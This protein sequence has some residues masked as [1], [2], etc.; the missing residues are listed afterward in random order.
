MG[1][2]LIFI[3]LSPNVEK[4]D[5]S[6]AFRLLFRPSLWGKGKA[7]QDLERKLSAYLGVKHAFAFN[8]GRSAF[9]AIL[10]GL[11]LEEGGEVLLQGF[12][13]NALVNPIIWSGLEPVYVDI[14]EKTLNM[15]PVDLERKVTEK[16]RAVVV[17]HTFGQPAE[18]KKI[19]EICDRKGL[20]LLED[21]AHSLG[22]EA[23]K[24]SG[25]PFKVGSFG[26]AGFFSFGRDKIISSVYGGMAVT[27]DKELAGKIK[28]YR[29]GL[30]LPSSFWVVQQLLHPLLCEGVVKPLYGF[31][32]IGRWVLAGFNRLGFLSKAV[33]KK[34]KYEGEKPSYIPRKMPNALAA[35]GSRQFEKLDRFLAHQKK[36]ANFYRENLAGLGLKLPL[37]STG[38]VY[39]R[40]SVLVK[41]V[42]TDKILK[43]ARKKNIFLDDGWRKTPLVPYDTDHQ[44]M[45]YYWGDCPTA[46]RVAR[47]IVN[48]PTSIQIS[49][50]KAKKITNFLKEICSSI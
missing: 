17:Q 39:M 43:K 21:C 42:D 31:F 38:R 14:D 1:K 9:L 3:S 28:R 20:I 49:N 35:L 2:N 25:G 18:L 29:G 13:C 7:V 10:N 4:D 33:Q 19:K 40:F 44:K 50:K 11:E 27:E 45:K 46:E 41:G 22:A 5:L 24:E 37:K 12:T 34:E 47:R 16:S 23:L 15:D 36:I 8:S 6:L 30:E 32:G 48:L 26:K